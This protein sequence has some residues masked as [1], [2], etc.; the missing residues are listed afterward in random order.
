MKKF[1]FINALSAKIGGGRT[2]I[3]NLLSNLPE[4]NDMY[5]IY[6]V[7]PDSTIVP[8]NEKIVYLKSNFANYNIL[9]RMIWEFFYLPFLLK[10]LKVTVL[11][12]PGGMDFNLF[13][14]GIP[15][16]TMFRNMLPFDKGIINK[17]PSKKLKFKNNLLKLLMQRTMS[18]AD[19]V[20]FISHYAK[21]IIKK[22]ISIKNSSVIYHGISEKFL[23][24]NKDNKISASKKYILYVS[25]F[26]PYKNHLNLIK[27]YHFLPIKLRE[28]YNLIL[29]GESME[30]SYSI[31]KQYVDK[32]NLNDFVEFKG[33]VNYQELPHLYANAEA[34]IFPSS[35]ENCPNI[36][37]EAIGCG[38]PVLSANTEP[39]PEFGRDAALYFDEKSYKDIN[40][41]LQK[42]LEN[43]EMLSQLRLKSQS[44]RNQ[45]L[46]KDSAL[47]TWNFLLSIRN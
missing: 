10:Y 31:C 39:M 24:S 19:H 6:I 25:R 13:T 14:F 26:E 40:L 18:M 1:I 36:L 12:S 43:P 8:Q 34:F 28:K 27:A 5:K 22:E 32:N 9:C 30:P 35:C 11:F 38:I 47:K 7:C 4:L 33:K 46:W 23:L 16:V 2:Y 17:L 37:L 3:Y 44:L 21:N 15:K 45:Y 41:I 29:A 42:V 20:I